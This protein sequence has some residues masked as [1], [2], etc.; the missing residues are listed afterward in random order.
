MIDFAVRARTAVFLHET[1]SACV[2]AFATAHMMEYAVALAD[3]KI[4]LPPKSRGKVG[5]E[6]G[7][8][9]A[10]KTIN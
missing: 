4:G 6:A 10:V 5:A 1:A 3:S 9:R 2:P 8:T 7:G